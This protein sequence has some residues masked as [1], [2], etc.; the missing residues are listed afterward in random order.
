[1]CNP[2]NRGGAYALSVTSE[3]NGHRLP[4]KHCVKNT[5]GPSYCGEYMVLRVNI[6]SGENNFDHL[7]VIMLNAKS[8]GR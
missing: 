6:L 5:Y 8:T 2:T 4:L 3:T 1:L 7:R